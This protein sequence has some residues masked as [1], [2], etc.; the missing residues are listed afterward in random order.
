MLKGSIAHIGSMNVNTFSG[1]ASP[2]LVIRAPMRIHVRQCKHEKQGRSAICSDRMCVRM[3]LGIRNTGSGRGRYALPHCNTAAT[4]PEMKRGT[5][6]IVGVVQETSSSRK[7]CDWHNQKSLWICRILGY[8][9]DIDTRKL[10]YTC[11]HAAAFLMRAR[12]THC[13]RLLDMYEPFFVESHD[14]GWTPL[15]TMAPVTLKTA[16]FLPEPDIGERPESGE[17]WEARV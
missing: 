15:C 10:R 4:I 5:P 9:H 3:Q 8:K 13:I 7:H 16:I 6:K 14:P 2:Y 17:A 12:L 1:N 11:R